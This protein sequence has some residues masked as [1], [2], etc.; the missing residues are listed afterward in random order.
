VQALL[1]GWN[2]LCPDTDNQRI[3]KYILV[4]PELNDALLEAW[5]IKHG[6]DRSR[7]VEGL[8]GFITQ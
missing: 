6:G 4:N 5:T 2:V 7:H 3:V 8:L 1:V